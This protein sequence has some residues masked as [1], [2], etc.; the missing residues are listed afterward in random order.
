MTE[1]FLRSRFSPG[2]RIIVGD[3]IRATVARVAFYRGTPEPI[4]TAEFWHEGRLVAHDV[5]EA[6]CKKGNE[7]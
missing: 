4:I 6:D 7:G 3:T 1:V 2:E 5:H